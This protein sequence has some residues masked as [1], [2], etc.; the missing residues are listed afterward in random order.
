MAIILMTE[1]QMPSQ[2]PWPCVHEHN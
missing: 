1:K 2:A